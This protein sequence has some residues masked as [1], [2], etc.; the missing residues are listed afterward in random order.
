M[1]KKILFVSDVPDFKGG[2]ENSLFDLMTNPNI[3]PILVVPSI[4]LIYEAAEIKLIKTEIV[5]FS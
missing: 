2:A 4:G 5:E 3:E 1:K